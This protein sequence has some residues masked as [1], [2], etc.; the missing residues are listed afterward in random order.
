MKIRNHFLY[1][2]NDNRVE[3]RRSPNQGGEITPEYLIMHYTAGSSGESSINHMLKRSAQASA[4]L[5][6]GRDG[7]I[8]QLV[9]F[10]KKAWHAGAS[11]WLGKT[12]INEFSIGIEL[13]NAGVFEHQGGQW[14]SWFGQTYPEN[15]TLK[16]FHQHG[17]VERGWHI[18]TQEQLAVALEVSECIFSHYRLMDVLGHDDISPGRKI[19]PGPAFP[20]DSFRSHLVGRA[21]DD[22]VTYSVISTSLNIRSGPGV[23]YEKK[24]E[25]PLPRNTQIHIQSRTGSWCFVDVINEDRIVD[26]TG[27]V[28]GDYIRVLSQ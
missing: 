26:M 22:P 23:E 19:D 7:R 12:G 11:R 10:N 16:A 2:T 15:E 9:P 18:Y 28:H 14:R 5:V 20:M 6:I 27:W 21:D 24:S 13:D 25:T 1:D 17:S 4:H 8:T 3:Y